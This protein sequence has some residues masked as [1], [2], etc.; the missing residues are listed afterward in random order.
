MKRMLILQVRVG[1]F[2]PTYKTIIGKK[3]IPEKVEI[4]IELKIGN[5]LMRRVT[6][7]L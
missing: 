3:H 6:S 5:Y 7:K 2:I 1:K 4:D